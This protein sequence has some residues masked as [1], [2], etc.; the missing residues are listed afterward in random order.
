LG[1]RACLAGQRV[2]FRTSTEWVAPL[3]EAQRQ[4]TLD[5]ELDRLER[6]QLL[7]WGWS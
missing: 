1:I 5:H 2:V 6:I 3:G 7:M 4:G